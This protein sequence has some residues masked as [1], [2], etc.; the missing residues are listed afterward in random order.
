[1]PAQMMPSVRSPDSP[2][3]PWADL[4]R[5]PMRVSPSMKLP[6]LRSCSHDWVNAAGNEKRRPLNT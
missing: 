1:M 2:S 5:P 6:L 3:A 4:R